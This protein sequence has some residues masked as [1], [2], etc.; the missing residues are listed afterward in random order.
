MKFLKS[1]ALDKNIVKV[2][3]IDVTEIAENVVHIKTPVCWG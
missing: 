2:M 1:L 3:K